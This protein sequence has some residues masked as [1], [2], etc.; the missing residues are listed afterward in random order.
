MNALR[1]YVPAVLVACLISPFALTARGVCAPRCVGD[2]NRDGA[3][4]IDELIVGVQIALG[5]FAVG[6][7]AAMDADGD[8]GVAIN[9]LVLAVQASLGSPPPPSPTATAVPVPPIGEHHCALASESV[10]NLYAAALP[11]PIPVRITGSIDVTCGAPGAG[12]AAPC[13]CSGEIE[14]QAVPGLGFVCLRSVPGCPSGQ[15]ACDGGVGLDLDL[16]A[17]GDIGSCDG[18]QAC[19][20]ACDASCAGA[21]LDQLSSS[22]TGYCAGGDN[23][24]QACRRDSQC[25]SGACNGQDPV[26]AGNV[27]QCQCA[28][29]T[30]GAA[31]PNGE[32][33]CNLGVAIDLEGAAPCGDGDVFLSIGRTCVPVTTGSIS[34]SLT[35]ANGMH[36]TD[37]PRAGPVRSSGQAVSCDDLRAGSTRGLGLRGGL[38]VFGSPLGDL[39]VE[40]SGDCE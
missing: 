20:T 7:C 21:G 5:A 28:N 12:G 17:D 11:V 32:M 8:G 31:G 1:M 4:T 27:C 18:N 19:A 10:I 13:D 24:G 30:A 34:L 14:P 3:V 6:R 22:C 26:S 29:L 37:I 40:M 36:G 35:D 9:E 23:D 2:C 15:I 39:V 16:V 25:P 38:S 33:R